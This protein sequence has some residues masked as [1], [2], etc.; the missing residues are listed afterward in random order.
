MHAST[1][2]GGVGSP[3]T[4]RVASPNGTCRL[5]R[6]LKIRLA[7]AHAAVGTLTEIEGL[8]IL[9]AAGPSALPEKFRIT[10]YWASM[11]TVLVLSWLVPWWG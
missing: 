1:F 8:Y 2:T 5:Q 11:R 10:E 9:L 4:S 6:V 3:H 7:T